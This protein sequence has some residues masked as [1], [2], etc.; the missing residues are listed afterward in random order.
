MKVTK[1]YIKG[2]QV[3][4]FEYEGHEGE[5]IKGT[6]IEA[7][8]QGLTICWEDDITEDNVPRCFVELNNT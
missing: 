5:A 6:V 7:K 8:L 2:D 4:T 1:D 3:V